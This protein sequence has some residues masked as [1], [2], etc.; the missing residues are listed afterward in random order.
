MFKLIQSQNREMK[1]VLNGGKVVW[2]IESDIESDIESE[3]KIISFTKDI[4][5]TLQRTTINIKNLPGDFDYFEYRGVRV[6]NADITRVSSSLARTT[7][8]TFLR[9]IYANKDYGRNTTVKFYKKVGGVILNRLPHL[10][11]NI[12]LPKVV[13]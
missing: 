10:F 1:E 4:F 6:D 13:A 7:H 2:K 3:S 9:A 5:I 12:V 8:R 11:A